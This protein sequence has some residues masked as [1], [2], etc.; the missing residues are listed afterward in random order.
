MLPYVEKT[1]LER[2]RGSFGK[3]MSVGI[4]NCL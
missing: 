4:E 2:Q 1:S 3:E